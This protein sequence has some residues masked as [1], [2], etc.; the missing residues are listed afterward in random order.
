MYV[1]CRF[2][3]RVLLDVVRAQVQLLARDVRQD[4][5]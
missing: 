1:V 3:Q 5:S 2:A 4:F